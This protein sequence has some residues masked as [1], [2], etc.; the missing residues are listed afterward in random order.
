MADLSI[1]DGVPVL[2][3]QTV[4]DA[5]ELIR[6]ITVRARSDAAAGCRKTE[7]TLECKCSPRKGTLSSPA[8]IRRH[9]D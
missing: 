7:A 5:R 3:D 1:L 9:V 8:W 2:V 4:W 6:V